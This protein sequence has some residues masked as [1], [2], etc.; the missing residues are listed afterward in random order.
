MKVILYGLFLGLAAVAVVSG[1]QPPDCSDCDLAS[2]SK[3][4]ADH[5]PAGVMLDECGCCTRCA[6]RLDQNCGGKFW[7]LGR[8]GRSYY[9]EGPHSERAINIGKGEVGFCR[10]REA[11]RVCG[12][13]GVVY[14]NMCALNET[15]FD[16][17]KFGGNK[18]EISSDR[19]IC[20]SAP[21]INLISPTKN[22]NDT[23][24]TSAGQQTYI[25]CEGEGFPTPTI[26]WTIDGAL[27]PGDYSNIAVQTIG[28]PREN[29]ATGW[30]MISPVRGTDSGTYTCEVDNGIGEP[31]SKSAHI[32]VS[33]D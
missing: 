1:Q 12:S 11:H 20:S 14:E 3:V 22:N 5:C 21:R 15:S 7:N 23:I 31:V 24:V 4:S 13:D 26:K 30:L 25:Q 2:C 6:R 9:C 18:I 27:L 10:C 33:E 28:G 32:A 17:L 29:Q 19:K 8:C 16:Q